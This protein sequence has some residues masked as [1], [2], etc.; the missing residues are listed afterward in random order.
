MVRG[1]KSPKGARPIASADQRILSILL[2]R[3]APLPVC[4][5]T[6]QLGGIERCR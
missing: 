6:R 1:G 5:D 2:G 4:Y 3:R